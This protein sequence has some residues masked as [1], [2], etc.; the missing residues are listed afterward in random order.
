MFVLQRILILLQR[1]KKIKMKNRLRVLVILLFMLVN[2]VKAHHY[3]GLPHYNYFDNYP[4]V[5]IFEYINETEDYTVFITIYNFQGLSLDMVNS[6]DDVRFYVY[7]Y[8]LNTDKSYVGEAQFNLY[9]HGEL[10][11]RFINI[12]QEEER[13]FS[14]KAAIKEQDDLILE[15]IFTDENGKEIIIPTSIEI[16]NSFFDEYGLYI[17]IGLFFLIV[18]IIKKFVDRK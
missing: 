3:K 4:Q 13:I 9:S 2:A 11:K 18:G 15:A 12:K 1:L 8:N 14:V 17:M 16:T 5:P 7:L 10:I 6:P